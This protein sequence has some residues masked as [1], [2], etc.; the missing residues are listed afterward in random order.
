[1]RAE[2]I[3][4]GATVAVAAVLTAGT[5]GVAALRAQNNQPQTLVMAVVR[6]PGHGQPGVQDDDVGAGGDR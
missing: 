5:I 2:T 1:M 4:R 3:V 6:R